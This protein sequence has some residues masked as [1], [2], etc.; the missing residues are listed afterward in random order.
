MTREQI[1]N[2]IFAVDGSCG[3]IGCPFNRKN[4]EE[5]LGVKRDNNICGSPDEIT[6]K[7]ALKAV[8]FIMNK[9]YTTNMEY[10][11]GLNLKK[12]LE[13]TKNRLIKEFTDRNMAIPPTTAKFI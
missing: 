6:E 9:K 11:Y 1:E 7:M 4:Q 5:V 13:D 8:K 3:C 12:K 10:Y 2:I